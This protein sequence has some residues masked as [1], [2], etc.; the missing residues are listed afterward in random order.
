M[1]KEY[2]TQFLPSIFQHYASYKVPLNNDL[3]V[4]G[5][6]NCIERCIE[7]SSSLDQLYNI[8]LLIYRY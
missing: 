7:N 5:F 3:A 1:H 4:L 2:Y 6:E 8:I